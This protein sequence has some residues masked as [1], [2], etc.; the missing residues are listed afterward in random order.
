MLSIVRLQNLKVQLTLVYHY[1][2]ELKK[3]GF[4]KPPLETNPH[5]KLKSSLNMSLPG[6][7]NLYMEKY[8]F[9]FADC[10]NLLNYFIEQEDIP[11]KMNPLHE[12]LL[13]F[14][15]Y[16]AKA[17]IHLNCSISQFDIIESMINEYIFSIL[18]KVPMVTDLDNLFQLITSVLD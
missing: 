18:P 16:L 7:Y 12:Q 2:M 8:K 1:E 9:S 15:L 5:D 17:W 14:T 13:L 6:L 11:E 3:H 4:V 10:I